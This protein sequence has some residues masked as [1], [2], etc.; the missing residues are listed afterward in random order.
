ME[1]LYRRLYFCIL[2]GYFVSTDFKLY[3]AQQR[4]LMTPAKE[5]LY[6]GAAGGG[7]SYLIRVASIV[8]SLEVPG[9]IT[10]LFR[11]TFKEVLSNH[12]YTPG[13]YLEMLKGLI[14]AGDCVFSKTDYSFAFYNGSRIQLAHSQYESD[15]FTHQGAQI[16]QLLIDEAT[17]FTPGMVR[18]IRSR[19]R[20]GSLIVPDKWKSHFPRILYTAN[21]GGVGHHY[22]KSNF[23]DHGPNKIYMAPEDEGS[24][25]REFVP[26]KLK[27]NLVM[28][29]SDPDYGA[30]LKGM[31]DTATVEAM[32]EGN[33][34][35]IST[36]G[37]GDLWRRKFHVTEPFAIPHTWK[38]DRGYDY[39]S[40]NPAA[41]VTFAES[42][43]S[44]F[45][46]ASGAECWVPAGSI[47][48]IG[49]VYFANRRHE[50]I[51]LT[52]DKQ[53]QRIRDYEIEEGL[54]ERIEPGPADNAIF[55]AEPGHRTVADD[56]ALSNV[57][58]VRGNKRPG[59]RIEGVQ[60]FRT[61]LKA[62]TER[63]LERPGFF[64]FSNCIHIIRTL[65]NLQNNEK[66]TEDIDTNG[67]DHFWDVIRYRI[68]KSAKTI[69]T[70]PVKG[71]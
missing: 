13:G 48:A 17:H 45:L 6:G 58:F 4:A 12:V 46:D 3:T 34:E 61:R 18:F 20:L 21:P 8:F 63:P 41:Y 26:A 5:V 54:H 23:V 30:R 32:L 27:D 37:F 16:G 33:W 25:T 67:E 29:K 60:L 39:G 47:F 69:S 68:L 42:D 44:E 15:I 11:R 53:G 7:K 71:L 36:G 2:L 56:M 55:S 49:E 31:G 9:L 24:M 35:I 14:D 40:S 50:G 22:F 1:N 62:A 70:I 51:K 57:K 28:L 52:A 38:I 65:P 59:S 66:N 43:G 19:V 10:Y 64:V